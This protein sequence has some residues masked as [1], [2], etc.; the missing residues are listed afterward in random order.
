MA[1]ALPALVLNRRLTGLAV[2]GAVIPPV[3][4]AAKTDAM[5][6]ARL[7]IAATLPIQGA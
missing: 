7:Q 1:E 2:S 3:P 5:D 6:R 4:I